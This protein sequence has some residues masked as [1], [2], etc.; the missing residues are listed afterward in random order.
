[1]EEICFVNSR[2][3]EQNNMRKYYESLYFRDAIAFAHMNSQKPF[4]LHNICTESW[5]L[6]LYHVREKCSSGIKHS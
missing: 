1:M 5:Q 3:Q 2:M 6:N 4:Y